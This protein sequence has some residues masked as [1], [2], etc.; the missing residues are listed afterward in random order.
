MDSS[1]RFTKY[2]L[3]PSRPLYSSIPERSQLPGEHTVLLPIW[4]ENTSIRTISSTVCSWVPTYKLP[5]SSREICVKC[6]SQGNNAK[7][8]QT[9]TQTQE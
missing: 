8:M 3:F 9:T 2:Y 6:L 4:R 1:K 5:G 7:P